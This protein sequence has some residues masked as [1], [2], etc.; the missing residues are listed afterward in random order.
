MK[1]AT[2]DSRAAAAPIVRLLDARGVDREAGDP[3][4]GTGDSPGHAGDAEE[5]ARSFATPLLSGR[6]L[7]T[8]EGVLAHAEGTAAILAAIGASP[9]L[10]AA[11]FL[12]HAADQLGQPDEVL[13]PPFG[14]SLTALVAN[15]RKLGDLQRAAQGARLADADQER[16]TERV[17]KMLLAFSRDLR[18]VLLR[19]ASRL[20]TLRFFAAAKL[21]CPPALATEAMQ[22]FAPLANR[23]GIWQIKWE[24]EDLAF[25]FLDPDQYHEIARLLDERRADREARVERLR[26]ELGRDLAAHGLAAQVQGRPKHLYSIARKMRRKSL[27]F[28]GVLDVLALRVIVADV[29]GCYAVL[30]R[31]HER[32][33]AIAGELDDYIARPKPNGYR[34]LHTV[35]EGDDG[36]AIEIQIRTPEMHEHAEYGVSAHWAYKEADAARASPSASGRFEAGVAAAR[37]VVLRQLLAWERDLATDDEDSASGELRAPRKAGL[38]DRLFVFTPQAT[39]VELT[40]GAT[41]IDFAYAVHTDLGH[42]CRGAKVDG[43]MMPLNTPLKSGQTVEITAAKSGGPSLDWLNPELGFLQ[44]VRSK[45]K[46]RAWFNALAQQGTI[47]RGRE[48]VEKVL[49]RE[50]KTALK[51]EDLAAQLGF[52]SAEALFEV[53]GKDELSL[54]AIEA[55]LR[56]I[57]E[58]KGDDG[59]ISLKRSRASASPGGVLV[60]GVESLLTSL[61]RCCRPAPPDAIAGY[62]TRGKGVAVHRASCSNLRELATRAPG[63]VIPVA[64]SASDSARPQLYPVDVSVEAADRQGLLRDVSEVF[65]KEKTNVIGVKSSSVRDARGGTAFMT[66]TV[67]VADAA[68]LAATLAQVCRVAGVRSARRR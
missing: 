67:E 5:R 9:E 52:R 37:L 48:A 19:L 15:A 28:S 64:W 54:R 56:P 32:Y 36:R 60:V 16:Q 24:L 63:R 29:P 51:L 68:R 44:S 58:P 31:V 66:F 18:V 17:R 12:V 46:V 40:A 61:A 50:G 7:P 34:S 65:A 1:S 13:T 8:G 47:A 38:D 23:L 2:A 21:S 22:V 3:R 45:A 20:Q 41:P 49:Q 4:A 43:A 26:E 11:A 10:R 14:A 39:V 30:G 27:D 33:R 42:R 59:E 55:L 25:R 57:P 53:V 35:V 62:V 6:S